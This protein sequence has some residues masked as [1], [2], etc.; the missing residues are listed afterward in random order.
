MGLEKYREKRRFEETPEPVGGERPGVAPALSFV[1]QKH[2]AS[3]LHYD[4]R[5]E[6]EGV[7]KSWAVPKGPSLNPKDK[8]LAMMVEDHPVEYGT[9]EGIIPEGNYG[10]GTVMLWDRGTLHALGTEDPRE[11]EEKLLEGLHKGHVTFI[12]DGARLKGEFALVRLKRGGENAWLLLKKGDEY[13]SGADVSKEDE[14]VATGRSMEEIAAGAGE[15][16]DI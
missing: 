11:S 6:M 7:L 13:A 12:L 2:L 1:V 4:L 14:S 9:F 10:A 3:H 5:L 15:S 16:G 8:R